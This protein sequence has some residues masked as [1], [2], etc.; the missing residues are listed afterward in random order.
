[1]CEF[2][3]KFPASTHVDIDQQGHYPSV[4][5]RVSLLRLIGVIGD[6]R[7]RLKSIILRE[8][9]QDVFELEITVA[10]EEG[11]DDLQ[12]KSGCVDVD[13]S[14]CVILCPWSR[15]ECGRER[16]TSSTEFQSYGG[17]RRLWLE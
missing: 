2:E 11:L 1:M 9:R 13:H 14:E 3:G 8:E 12:L 6:L 16:I 4:L 5:L 15:G 7:E 10:F 17:P